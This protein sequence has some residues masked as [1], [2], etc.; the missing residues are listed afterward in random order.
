[1]LGQD[2][3]RYAFVVFN[4]HLLEQLAACDGLSLQEQM[5]RACGDAEKDY[6]E[7]MGMFAMPKAI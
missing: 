1:M 6:F 2:R 5:T 3:S 4:Q 7:Q